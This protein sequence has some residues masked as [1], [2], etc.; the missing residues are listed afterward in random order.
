MR[1]RID[2]HAVPAL[3]VGRALRELLRLARLEREDDHPRR[4]A[5]LLAVV[6]AEAHA[7]GLGGERERAGGVGEVRDVEM[8]NAKPRRATVGCRRR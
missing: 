2:R 8:Q 7:R 3:Q 1:R 6:P 4:P 5:E